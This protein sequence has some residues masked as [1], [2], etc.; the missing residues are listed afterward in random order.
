MAPIYSLL[1]PRIT[2]GFW[3]MS[4]LYS[5]AS[6][7]EGFHFAHI[8]AYEDHQRSQHRLRLALARQRENY[9]NRLRMLSHQ[10]ENIT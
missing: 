1:E 3:S 9:S 7:F 8:A 4:Y 10:Q 6:Y 5:E 2:L